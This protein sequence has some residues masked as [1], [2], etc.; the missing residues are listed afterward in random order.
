LEFLH[1]KDKAIEL[2]GEFDSSKTQI[3]QR[4]LFD[5]YSEGSQ[6]WIVLKDCCIWSHRLQLLITIKRG[7]IT[8]F[9]SIPRLARFLFTGHGKTRYP[10]LPHDLLYAIGRFADP[11]IERKQ[12]DL[13]LKDMCEVMCMSKR[14]TL[15]VHMAVRSG[16]WVAWYK[17]RE[18]LN[19]ATPDIMNKY[20]GYH[21]ELSQ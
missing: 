13:V 18:S 15:A 19:F 12:V 14:A 4:G 1:D 21:R 10:A 3:L 8:D 6:E 16:G 17:D 20:S 11:V 9:A 5:A 2:F 7:F